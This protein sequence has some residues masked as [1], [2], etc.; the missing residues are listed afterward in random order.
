MQQP[1]HPVHV[2]WVIWHLA[3]FV[4]ILIFAVINKHICLS[5]KGKI[6]V[7]SLLPAGFVRIAEAVAVD[8]F[9]GISKLPFTLTGCRCKICVIKGL[10]GFPIAQP[11][12]PFFLNQPYCIYRTRTDNVSTVIATQGRRV[13][14][15]S[16]SSGSIP[17]IKYCSAGILPASDTK[18]ARCSHYIIFF[19]NWDAPRVAIPHT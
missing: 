13:S 16:Q 2:V 11:N 9:P 7:F 10:L 19:K 14:S 8:G 4:L 6:R 17:N 15:F 12:L 3:C 1:L 5:I 18:G